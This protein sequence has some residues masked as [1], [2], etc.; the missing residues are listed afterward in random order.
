MRHGFA[1]VLLDAGVS[2]RALAEYL[3]HTD[4]GFTLRVYAHTMPNSEAKIR[5]AIDRA[6]AAPSEAASAPHVRP[7]N[8]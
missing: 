2:I 7:V 1:L 8:G 5:V 3:G 4:P 6:W